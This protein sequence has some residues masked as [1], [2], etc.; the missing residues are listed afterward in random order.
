[1][2]HLSFAAELQQLTAHQAPLQSISTAADFDLLIEAG[3]LPYAK[4]SNQP[5]FRNQAGL[6]EDVEAAMTPTPTV[7]LQQ[8]PTVSFAAAELHQAAA[9][10]EWVHLHEYGVTIAPRQLWTKLSTNSRVELPFNSQKLTGQL[11]VCI[12]AVRALLDNPSQSVAVY[13]FFKLPECVT[14]KVM[15]YIHI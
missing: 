14:C 2:S 4:V 6:L 15:S 11:Y 12:V 1:L 8:P 10:E 3:Q 7:H 13:G 5:A 9:P